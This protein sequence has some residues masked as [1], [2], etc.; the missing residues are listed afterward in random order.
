MEPMTFFRGWHGAIAGRRRAPVTGLAA[1]AIIAGVIV[2]GLP[3][4]PSA[5]AASA[6]AR[7]ATSAS[8]RHAVR[9]YIVPAPVK[10]AT[11]TLYTIAARTLGNGSRYPEIFRLAVLV[12]P[13]PGDWDLVAE[14]SVPAILV[15]SKSLDPSELAAAPARGA[16]ALVSADKIADHFRS[17]LTMVGQGYLVVDSSPMRRLIGAAHARWDQQEPEPGSLP[18]LTARETD[19][20]RSAA[21]GHSIRRTAQVLGIAPKT[22]EN[23]QTRLFRKLGVRNRSGALAVADAFGLLPASAPASIRPSQRP[24]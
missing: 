17:V 4:G 6:A 21:Q 1:A 11:Q 24:G 7:G 13:E 23:I 15:H 12:D 20:L 2:A 9:Y 14:L 22:V 19:I 5:L 16:S 10:G 18:E 8:S 3:A